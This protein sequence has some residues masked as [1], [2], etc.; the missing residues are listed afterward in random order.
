M[1]NGTLDRSGK[2]IEATVCLD[3]TKEY[4]EFWP[5]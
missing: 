1:K 5:P 3:K 2:I 4:L